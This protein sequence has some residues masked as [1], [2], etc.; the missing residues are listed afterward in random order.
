MA[1]W[2]NGGKHVRVP[3][4]GD[5]VELVRAGVTLRGRVCY[6][7]HLQVL[8]ARDDGRSASLRIGRDRFRILELEA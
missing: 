8:V 6:A 4:I 7:D 2:E 1:E 3:N 5:R